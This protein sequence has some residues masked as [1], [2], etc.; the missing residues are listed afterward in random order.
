MTP[1]DRH[2]SLARVVLDHPEC[3]RVL[4]SHRLDYC[5][6]G[7]LTIAE[8]CVGK[9]VDAAALLDDLEDAIGGRAGPPSQDPRSRTTSEL[10]ADLRAGHRRVL[11]GA[12]RAGALL[13][14]VAREQDARFNLKEVS[15][16]FGE[17]VSLLIRHADEE[18]GTL[19]ARLLSDSASDAQIERGF[20]AARQE[21]LVIGEHVTRLRSLT[22]DFYTP[23]ETCEGYAVLMGKLS[24]LEDDL[25]RH[26]HVANHVLMPRFVRA[27]GEP[28]WSCEERAQVGLL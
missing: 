28:V 22:H 26:V 8:A 3:A 20:R 25:C 4:R 24:S 15:E 7:A 10:V 19:F 21:H 5:C 16:V 1:I 17:L 13:V 12:P 23:A 14:A 6:R 18:E 9:G 11:R 27:A 2:A